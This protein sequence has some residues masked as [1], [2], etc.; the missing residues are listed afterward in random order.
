MKTVVT[1]G[2]GFIG[3]HLVEQLLTEDNEVV[4]LDDFSTGRRENLR[5]VSEHP[6]LTVVQGSVCD[7]ALVTDVVK[8]ADRVFHLAAA[9]GQFTIRDRTLESL[10]TNL[11]G[12]ETVIEAAWHA[13]ARFLL[14]STSE[15][16]GMNTKIGL[17]EDDLRIIGSPL[18]SRW[19]YS[20]AKAI[21]ET[22]TQHYATQ[23]GLPAVIVRLFNTVGPRQTGRYGMVIPRFVSQALAGAPLTVYGTGQQIRCFG[24]VRDMVPALVALIADVAAHSEVFNLGS[25]EPIAIEALAERIIEVTGSPSEIVRQPYDETFYPGFEDV[26]RRIPDCR[27]AR[28]QIGFAPA[29]GLDAII[30]DVVADQRATGSAVDAH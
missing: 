21:D 28:D 24:H 26:E 9:V 8:D 7:A 14:T 2:A 3:S 12:T 23:K 1:G 22:V 15:I 10:H 11:H 17:A 27:R 6:A 18:T 13:G 20:D 25:S 30:E 5:H 29:R 4:V 16:Y 19:S